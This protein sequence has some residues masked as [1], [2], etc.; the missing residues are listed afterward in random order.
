MAMAG[1][2]AGWLEVALLRGPPSAGECQKLFDEY[3]IARYP[4]PKE[5]G[6]DDGGEWKAEFKG[7]C[8]NMGMKGKPASG[9]NPQSNAMLERAHQVFGGML[10][11]FD[12]DNAVLDENE[13][14]QKFLA[15][16]AYAIRSTYLTTQQATPAQLAYGRDM[17]LPAGYEANWDEITKRKQKRINEN[18]DRENKK[19]ID[20]TFE[21]GGK[22]LLSRP[23]IKLRKLSQPRKG[24]YRILKVNGNGSLKI[25]LRPCV[26]DVVNTRRVHPFFEK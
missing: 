26:T 11:T 21:V 25:Q 9:W 7:L 6:F 16:T 2:V 19:R 3:W 22:V 12:L 5:V 15:D 17:A 13:P 10:R 24:P 20:H 23:G 14:F 18:N 4:R 8:A 1:P